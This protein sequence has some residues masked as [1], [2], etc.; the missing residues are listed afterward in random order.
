M[1]ELT[2]VCLENGKKLTEEEI[3]FLVKHCMTSHDVEVF[4]GV[5]TP[6]IHRDPYAKITLN[7]ALE[8]REDMYVRR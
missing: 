5:D 1:D 4:M 2:N 6:N 7:I 3:I 8:K